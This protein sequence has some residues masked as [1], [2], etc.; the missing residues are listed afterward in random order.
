MFSKCYLDI[1]FILN[2][3][4]FFCF[5]LFFITQMF[6]YILYTCNICMVMKINCLM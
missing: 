1:T 5:E 2:F 3:K 4:P 6:M